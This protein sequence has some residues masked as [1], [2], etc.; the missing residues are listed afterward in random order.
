[1]SLAMR[2]SEARPLPPG[3][4]SWYFLR[5]VPVLVHDVCSQRTLLSVQQHG[6]PAEGNCGNMKTCVC[7][8]KSKKSSA[9]GQQTFTDAEPLLFLLFFVSMN[10]FGMC[11]SYT[12][13]AKKVPQKQPLRGTPSHPRTSAAPPLPLHLRRTLI[14]NIATRASPRR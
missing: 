10:N 7:N 6:T 1:M 4:L 14:Q 8:K 9:K 12:F 13:L 3:S 11:F 5:G 2:A